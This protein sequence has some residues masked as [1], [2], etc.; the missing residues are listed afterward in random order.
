MPERNKVAVIGAGPL[1][2][3]AIK[4]FIEDGFE[5]T[6][7]ESRPYVGGL[8][9]DSG[10]S[11]ISVH[12]TTIFNSSKF[13][14]AMTDFPFPEDADVY[15]TA[16]QLHKYLESY[17]EHF[18]LTKNI[19]LSSRVRCIL[20]QHDQWLLEVEHDGSIQRHA[21]D[22]VC[23]ATGSFYTPRWPKLSGLE[24]FKGKVMHSIDFH[25]SEPFKDE[26]VLVIGLHATAQDVTNALS[27]SAKHVYLSHRHGL[28]LL[29]RFTELGEAFDTTMKLPLVFVQSWLDKN[30]P[31]LGFWLF[32]KMCNNASSKAF[33]DLPKKLGLLPAPSLAIST[34]L[35]GDTIYPFLESGFAEPVPAVKHIIDGNTVELTDGRKLSNIDSIIYCTGYHFN[36]PED[37]VPRPGSNTSSADYHPYPNGPGHNPY[38][39]FNMFPLSSDP[40]IRD[41]L[42]F[43]GQG[44]TTY[45]GFVQ[46]EL[47]ACSISQIW[48]GN[49]SLPPR[50]EMLAWYE[51]HSKWRVEQTGKYNAPEGGTFYPSMIPFHSYFDFINRTAGTGIFEHFGGKFSGLFNWTSWKLW[52]NDRELYDLCT[53]GIL[54]PTV[55]RVFD[56]GGRKAFERDEA[57]KRLKKDN[58]LFKKA[59]KAKHEQLAEKKKV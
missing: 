30:M 25:G 43:L 39:Y 31:R 54:S 56:Y 7:F 8:W 16:V 48:R 23:V 44:A 36:I 35:M 11:T 9:K 18:G 41:S 29:P 21:F 17:A 40:S 32:D 37:L 55:F 13:R 24:N 53:K 38:L 42:A 46:F 50:D 3:M 26:N 5:V 45:P 20:R 52:W 49:K 15:P 6:A 28:L 27:D 22:R 4:Q 34:P 33:P 2:L 19:R 47:A 12:A 14:T 51:Q 10:D 59:T 57:V 58:E 1:G